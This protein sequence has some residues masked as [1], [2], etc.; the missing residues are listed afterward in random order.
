MYMFRSHRCSI[1][2]A[3]CP[4]PRQKKGHTTK[5]KQN[6]TNTLKLKLT[7]PRAPGTNAE[8]RIPAYH[9]YYDYYGHYYY[10]YNYYGDYFV[11]MA[12]D[13]HTTIMSPARALTP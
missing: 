2:L 12:N 11:A 3:H 9:Y 10:H 6:N 1:L 8:C 4:T 5:T 13:S 7:Q